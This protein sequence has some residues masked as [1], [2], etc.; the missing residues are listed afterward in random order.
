M[1]DNQC[2]RETQFRAVEIHVC[3]VHIAYESC[4]QC[5]LNVMIRIR[6]HDN[7]MD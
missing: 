4:A 6:K 2:Q 5:K 3:T 7:G 1:G